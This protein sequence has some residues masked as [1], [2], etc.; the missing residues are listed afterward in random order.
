MNADYFSLPLAEPLATAAG[1]ITEREGFLV[2]IDAPAP[3][4]GEACPLPGWT[5]SLDECR[6]ALESADGGELDTLPPAARHG[7]SLAL[8]DGAARDA[9]LPLYRHFGRDERVESVPVNATVGDAATE[10]AVE[11]VRD[12]VDA[13]FPAVK[14]KVGARPLGTD[15]DRVRAVRDACPD[16]ELRLDANGA[17]TRAE[18]AE[19]FAALDAL[20]VAYVEQPLP[21]GDLAG[22][23]DLRRHETGVALDEGLYEHGVDAALDAGAADTWILKPMAMGGPDVALEAAVLARGAGIDPV[24]TTTIDGAVARA[25]AVHV[26]AALPG[27]RACGLATGDLL[28]ADFDP[29]PAPV[30][31][32]R[33]R[34]PQ[35]EGNTGA[36]SPADYA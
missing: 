16:V 3:G 2:G 15:L 28:A 13:G 32:G 1:D 17:W 34:V 10:T 30:E 6:A 5:E 36:T 9:G 26:A 25:A 8:L 4:L 20:D 24:V 19:A 29:D 21:A 18:A 14:L 7:V 22:H 35:K 33:A 27:V 23:A 12:S 11:R 31:S